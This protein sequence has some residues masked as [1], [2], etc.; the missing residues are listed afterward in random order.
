MNVIGAFA[1]AILVWAAVSVSAWWLRRALR[2][3][4]RH[5]RPN[6][7]NGQRGAA[8]SSRSFRKPCISAAV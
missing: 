5:K 6:A 4:S 3:T 2:I 7:G 8:A 1:V